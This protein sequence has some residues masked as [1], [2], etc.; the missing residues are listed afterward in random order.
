METIDDQGRKRY[1]GH[2]GT[3]GALFGEPGCSCKDEDK[4]RNDPQKPVLVGESNPYGADPKFALFPMPRNSAG[5][6]L[7]Y[8]IMDLPRHRYL[9]MYDRVNLC[10]GKWNM[11]EARE[12]ADGLRH[13]RRKFVLLGRKVCD[14]FGIDF[15]PFTIQHR[16][17]S[18]AVESI[19]KVP[20]DEWAFVVLPHPSGRNRLWNDPS[21]FHKAEAILIEAK[22]LGGQR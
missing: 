5:A 19:L 3:C 9:A 1:G 12:R 6:R 15:E 7:C 17:T 11:K 10:A 4:P 18:A 22:I 16:M 13:I 8:D 21:A 14:A 2:L 20:H